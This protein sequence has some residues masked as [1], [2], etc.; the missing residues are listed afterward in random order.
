[1]QKM[2]SRCRWAR[3][4]TIAPAGALPAGSFGHALSAWAEARDE[5]E[6][7]RLR[8]D[9][10]ERVWAERRTLAAPYVGVQKV[11][12]FPAAQGFIFFFD[13]VV[14][15]GSFGGAADGVDVFM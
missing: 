5:E 7:E 15:R 14:R 9:L 8:H 11:F 3:L 12:F 1:M 4:P 6:H 13:N 10:A 2:T